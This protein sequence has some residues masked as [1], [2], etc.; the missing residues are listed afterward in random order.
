MAK[1]HAEKTVS[2]ARSSINR[3]NDIEFSSQ[4]T[5]TFAGSNGPTQRTCRKSISC[6]RDDINIISSWEQDAMSLS[7]D[8]TSC[9]RRQEIEICFCMTLRGLR[10]ICLICSD[11]WC[12]WCTE[13]GR[14]TFYTVVEDTEN[15]NS[16]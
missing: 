8:T 7:R 10:N 15:D 2:C 16:F 5:Y 6:A 3:G 13:L 14:G 9:A 12:Y 11:L 1:K 4:S